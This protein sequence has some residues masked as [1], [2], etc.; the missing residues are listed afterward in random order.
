MQYCCGSFVYE[1]KSFVE[2]CLNN[3]DKHDM[4]VTR[5][6]FLICVIR[7]LEISTAQN[8]IQ[9]LMCISPTSLCA[10]C[11]RNGGRHFVVDEVQENQELQKEPKN[12]VMFYQTQSPSNEVSFWS[13]KLLSVR[14]LQILKYGKELFLGYSSNYEF[15]RYN[16]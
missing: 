15:Q 12:D 1:V 13:C 3:Y 11:Y 6:A 2:S 5:K 7:N 9:L 16:I 4:K 14:A 8:M 10:A